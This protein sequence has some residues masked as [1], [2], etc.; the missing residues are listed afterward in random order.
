M[1]AFLDIDKLSDA[2]LDNRISDLRNKMNIIMRVTENES[3]AES[4]L[5]T[6][7]ML[8]EEKTFR[9]TNT[10]KDD[11]KE[12]GTVFETGPYDKGENNG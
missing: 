4:I 3:L 10:V 8:E 6:I 12:R 9:L 5:Y 11:K 2:E 1:S 7:R